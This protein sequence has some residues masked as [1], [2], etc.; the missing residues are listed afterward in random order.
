MKKIEAV[1]RSSKV[2]DV[3]AALDKVGIPG[4]MI[5]E[6]D[7]HGKQKGIEQQLCGGTYKLELLPESRIEVVVS[8]GEVDNI[9]NTIQEAAF[10]GKFGD[11]KIFIYILE[12]AVRI[13]TSEQGEIAA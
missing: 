3:R 11:G 7:S 1:I 4:A 6:I 5:S 12:D 2:N 9:V 8:D 13:N 10:T